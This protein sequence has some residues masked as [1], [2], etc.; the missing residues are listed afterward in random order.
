MSYKQGTIDL[1]QKR[2]V[3]INKEAALIQQEIQRL[4]YSEFEEDIRET[5]NQKLLKG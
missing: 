4:Q 1:L 2:L 5:E 3:E